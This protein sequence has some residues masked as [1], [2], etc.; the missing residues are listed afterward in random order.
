[1]LVE[2]EV[3]DEQ[4]ARRVG[5]DGEGEL[6]AALAKEALRLVEH[7]DVAIVDVDLDGM[8]P[9]HEDP[10]VGEV[11]HEEAVW[12]ASWSP[13]GKRLATASLD[14]TP[15]V[16]NSVDV[17]SCQRSCASTAVKAVCR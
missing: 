16:W 3:A 17:S 7:C 14:K 4:V 8:V 13:D 11:R 6:G 9:A 2:G 12:S 10:P 1:M 5:F 15:R